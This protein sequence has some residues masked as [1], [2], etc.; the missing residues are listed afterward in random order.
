MSTLQ[1]NNK[2]WSKTMAKPDILILIS[3]EEDIKTVKE[4]GDKDF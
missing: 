2:V 1:L 3:M 4:Q